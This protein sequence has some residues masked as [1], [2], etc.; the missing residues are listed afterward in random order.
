MEREVLL[1]RFIVDPTDLFEIVECLGFIDDH[2]RYE[3]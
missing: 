2:I 3:L 1:D